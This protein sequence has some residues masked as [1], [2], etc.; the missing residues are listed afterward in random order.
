MA[1]PVAKVIVP[2]PSEFWEVDVPVP[3]LRLPVVPS[4]AV[5][6]VKLIDPPA[7]LSPDVLPAVIVTSPP[8]PLVVDPTPIVMEPASPELASPVARKMDPL[9]PD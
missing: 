6:V 4:V 1:A 9:V 7:L 5:P 8:A 2:V 3:M